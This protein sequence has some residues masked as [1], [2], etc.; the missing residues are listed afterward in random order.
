M[1]CSAPYAAPDAVVRRHRACV[2]SHGADGDRLNL[3]PVSGVPG[4]M[5]MRDFAADVSR[6]FGAA[7][8]LLSA[9]VHLDVWQHGFRDIHTIGPL[10]P[11]VI[12]V[13][14]LAWRRWL[15]AVAALGYGAAIVVAFWISVVHG[16]F[17]VKETV[18]GMPEVLAKLAAYAAVFFG[19]AAAALLWQA[20]R[21]RDA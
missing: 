8:V 5:D 19:L 4:G 13:A 12:G 15:P 6:A 3:T 18:T 1:A 7:G 16:L 2:R 21:E 11:L 20:M 14:I 10:F 9:V 17:G